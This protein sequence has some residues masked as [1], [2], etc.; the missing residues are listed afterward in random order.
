MCT[1]MIIHARCIWCILVTRHRDSS[2]AQMRSI[3]LWKRGTY[4]NTR[5]NTYFVCLCLCTHIPQVCIDQTAG[6]L[7]EGLSAQTLRTFSH[8]LVWLTQYANNAAHARNE[9]TYHALVCIS[10][11]MYACACAFIH[12]ERIQ[13][14]RCVICAGIYECKHL[15]IICKCMYVHIYIYIHIYIIYTDIYKASACLN[16]HRFAHTDEHRCACICAWHPR[17]DS[18]IHKVLHTYTYACNHAVVHE[19]IN[20]SH[21]P[22]A[23]TLFC[24]SIWIYIHTCRLNVNMHVFTYLYKHVH[25][26]MHLNGRMHG[27]GT[28]S[29]RAQPSQPIMRWKLSQT[30]SVCMCIGCMYNTCIF[31]C[32]PN[33]ADCAHEALTNSSC[34]GAHC[35]V[36]YDTV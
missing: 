4:L 3:P 36:S 30:V 18:K 23:G 11:R 21:L 1:D 10:W 28:L 8:S 16:E 29:H 14:S 22:A 17:Y 25:Y 2:Q 9:C 12:I 15:C 35:R 34:M 26:S 31:S 5:S 32:M 20:T 13:A 7:Q 19:H 27:R 33:A 24:S 6:Q